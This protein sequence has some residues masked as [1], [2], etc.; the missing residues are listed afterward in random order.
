MTD[1]YY[2]RGDRTY[3]VRLDRQSSEFTADVEGSHLAGRWQ[4]LRPGYFEIE[5]PDRSFRCF[6]AAEGDSR[7]L[8]HEGAVYSL[9][10]YDP[11]EEA[12][13]RRRG[14][15]AGGAAG[16]GTGSGEHLCPL[17]GKVLKLIAKEGA[18]V[19]AGDPLMIV[20][21]MKMEHTIKAQVNGMIAK[22]NFQPGESVEAGVR[23][24]EL[25]IPKEGAT[26]GKSDNSDKE[27]D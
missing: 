6:V 15:G 25:E 18:T 16:G 12:R 17:A 22:F 27:G 4:E 20:E 19:N 14:G 8:F 21:A 13:T 26:N 5:L 24:L 3:T 10:S 2:R 23:L 7:Y 9:S 11:R 1:H